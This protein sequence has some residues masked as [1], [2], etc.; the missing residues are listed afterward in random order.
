VLSTESRTIRC[1]Q[2]IALGTDK[3]DVRQHST[4]PTGSASSHESAEGPAKIIVVDDEAAVRDTLKRLLALE[5]FDV[6][7]AEGIDEA[8]AALEQTSVNAVVLDVHM[9]DS[10][11][12]QRSGID[13]LRFIRNHEHLRQIPVLILSGGDLTD[14]EE[15]AILDLDAYVFDKAD[16]W[17]LLFPYLK[18]LAEPIRAKPERK[19]SP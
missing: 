6:C 19:T 12:R 7:V 8:V 5:G 15:K 16:G 11:G 10:T 3:G 1:L 4:R 2:G 13:V 14:S 17:R 18:H 9:P